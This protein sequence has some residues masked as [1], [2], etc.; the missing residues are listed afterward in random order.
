M[1]TPTAPIRS[2]DTDLRHLRR[3]VVRH[4]AADGT[5][6]AGHGGAL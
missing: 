1:T 2:D 5:R 6:L 4:L 3:S